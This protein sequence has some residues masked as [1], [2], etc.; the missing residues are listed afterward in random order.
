MNGEAVL[1]KET[2]LVWEQSPDTTTGTWTNAH[3]H[4]FSQKVGGRKGWR[5]PTIEEL[6]TLVDDTQSA[7]MIPAEL[8]TLTSN[9]QSPFYWASTTSAF[10][11]T[12]AW[13]VNMAVG[14]AL[15]ITK[16]TDGFQVW[17]V[18]GGQGHDAY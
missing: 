9:V 11:P 16:T 5:V 12:F 10:N 6:L 13:F 17:C 8:K 15:S 2:C 18:R 3:S 14:R 1:D 4:C 7:P